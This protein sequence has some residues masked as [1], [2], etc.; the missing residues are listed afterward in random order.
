MEEKR[1]ELAN[2]IFPEA[3]TLEYYEKKYPERNL[4]SDAIVTRFAPSPTGFTHIGGIYQCVILD[5][6]TKR[7]GGLMFLRIEDTDQEREI[8][9][10]T[11]KILE[12]LALF[13]IKFDEGNISENEAIGNYGPYKQSERKEIYHAFAKHLIE[14]R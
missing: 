13:N 5:I 8:E 3:E 10:G 6:I 12:D 1:K 4:E 7:S 2:L 11:V 9:N 14:I